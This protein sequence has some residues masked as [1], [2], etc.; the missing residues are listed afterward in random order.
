M[1][2]KL[3]LSLLAVFFS[4]T[5]M[6]QTTV[7]LN[8]VFN[9]GGYTVLPTD[10]DAG[11]YA[12]HWAERVDLPAEDLLGYTR[13]VDDTNSLRASGYND[14]FPLP[15][16]SRNNPGISSLA[17]DVYAVMPTIDLTANSTNIQEVS[18]ATMA[19]E[20]MGF[21]LATLK[22]YYSTD[23]NPADSS[24]TWNEI[25][26]VEMDAMHFTDKNWSLSTI[27]LDA[28]NTESAFTLAYRM[29]SAADALVYTYDSRKRVYILSSSPGRWY[30]SDVRFTATDVSENPD[31]K[32][33]LIDSESIAD[34]EDSTQIYNYEMPYG[35]TS[36]PDV[37]GIALNSKS[38]VVVSSGTFPVDPVLITVTSEVGG[39]TKVYTV[40]ITVDPGTD[41]TLQVLFQDGSPMAGF[42]SA[43]YVYNIE[44]PYGSE[45]PVINGLPTKEKA[46]IESVYNITAFPDTAIITVLAEN[47]QT[48]QEYKVIFTETPPN[49]N[50]KLEKI[51]IRPYDPVT[52]YL[53]ST[54][55]QDTLPGVFDYT[56][57]LPAGTNQYPSHIDNGR[58]R[59]YRVD[60]INTTFTVEHAGDN[61]VE[62]PLTIITITAE[63]G[64]TSLQ[65]FIHYYITSSDDSLAA[66]I[67]NGE[68]VEDFTSADTLYEVVLPFGTTEI[69]F[70]GATASSDSASVD[71]VQIDAVPA[72]GVADTAIVTVTAE[73]GVSI[74]DY[75]VIFTI[76]TGDD[77]TLSEITVA[78]TAIT[79]FRADSTTYS[80]E[81][82]EGTTTVP[83]IVATASD[84]EADVSIVAPASVPG[85][86]TIT[87]AAA[88]GVDSETY[89]VEL[90]VLVGVRDMYSEAGLFWPN[91]V[92]D[93]M[94][95]DSRVDAVEIFSITGRKVA[96][97]ENIEGSINM[98]AIDSGVYFLR[99]EMNDNSIK[100]A[101]FIKR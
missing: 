20:G 5:I 54:L 90:T 63:D 26:G 92:V 18:F 71:T 89:T 96:R 73:D 13:E 80:V 40:N 1:K 91:P 81:L 69:P 51:Y 36:Y 57:I 77:A 58:L 23:Y 60:R 38:N 22:V 67:V 12:Y 28:Y 2:V 75:Y 29:E 55:G 42:D 101:K 48:R 9:E 4:A 44:L 86:A 39:H 3:L 34:F 83:A 47:G 46:S 14:K 68:P 70:V 7:T 15:A 74:Q 17:L 33:I 27:N 59:S 93:L 65:Y 61:V 31:L 24:G 11:T 84:D 100:T 53:L 25:T 21:N 56:F 88:N 10:A 82:P 8:T 52:G 72:I 95:I 16:S 41:A 87:V 62:D 35:S 6:A 19:T 43:I 30:L 32:D 79:G 76:N 37:K 78:G 66:L 50:A 97:E 49:T 94:N 85:T 64:V 45:M 98:S 99:M